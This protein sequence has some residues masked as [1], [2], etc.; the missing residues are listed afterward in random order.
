[1][2]RHRP[3]QHRLITQRRQIRDRLGTIGDRH[4]QIGQHL[5]TIV[6][7]PTLLGRRH[8][9]RQ[10]RRQPDHIRKID[11]QPSTR[12]TGHTDPV[13]R[14]PQRPRD[15]VYASPCKCP[16]ACGLGPSTS[17]SFPHQKGTSADA[18]PSATHPL[19]SASGPAPVEPARVRRRRAPRGTPPRS[20][21][22]G[23]RRAPRA[24]GPG[25]VHTSP[26]PGPAPRPA[27]GCA[28]A[29][30]RPVPRTA[31]ARRTPQREAVLRPRPRIATP[32]RWPR[33]ARRRGAERCRRA[34]PRP[35][36]LV[37]PGGSRPAAD[38]LPVR[39]PPTPR[40]TS[41]RS[42]S[43]EPPTRG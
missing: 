38:V 25:N 34:A 31:R 4:S 12:M 27:G 36:V 35:K 23:A 7:P 9:H 40:R 8:R 5:A 17:P 22:T 42:A 37:P 39:R 32:P 3:E 26:S 1:M 19:Q 14:D 30:G 6:T 28:S 24:A 18:P 2:R 11:Q 10:P 33:R 15:A 43:R 13:A 21:Q 41:R 29:T 20:P 16:S